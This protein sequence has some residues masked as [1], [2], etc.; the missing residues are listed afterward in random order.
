MGNEYLC[1]LIFTFFKFI[2]KNFIFLKIVYDTMM[3][4]NIFLLINNNL[5]QFLTDTLF[6]YKFE[7]FSIFFDDA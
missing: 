6:F 7:V 1:H 5:F 3:S 2:L 4:P